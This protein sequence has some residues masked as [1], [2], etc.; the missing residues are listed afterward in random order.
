MFR[1]A[2]HNAGLSLVELLLVLALLSI[3][4]ALLLPS[5]APN[6]VE[7]LQAAAQVTA[8]DLAYTRSLAVAGGSTYRVSFDVDQNRYTIAHSGTNALLD[9]LPAFPYD[10]SGNGA[11]Q[12]VVSLAQLPWLATPPRLVTVRTAGATP[13]TVSSLEFGPLGAT[14]QSDPTHVWLGAGSG[15]AARY[16]AVQVNPATGIV[17]IGSLQANHP[18]PAAQTNSAATVPTTPP[19]V[20]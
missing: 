7:Q 4:A 14:T 3:F 20:P 5:S 18:D 15:A 12:R 6:Q 2:R 17:S 8:A 10:Q 11:T 13:A 16:L 1:R 9:A 19:D